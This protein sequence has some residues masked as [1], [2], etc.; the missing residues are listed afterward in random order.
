MFDCFS[1]EAFGYTVTAHGKEWET[2]KN[3]HIRM[4]RDEK[5]ELQIV[6]RYWLA[7]E[8]GAAL[9]AVPHVIY[10]GVERNT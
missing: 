7:I 5:G 6:G 8:K 10:Q 2:I 1:A 3:L 9:P 4:D